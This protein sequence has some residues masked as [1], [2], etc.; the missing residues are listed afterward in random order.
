MSLEEQMGARIKNLREVNKLSLRKLGEVLGMDYSYLAKLEKGKNSPNLTTLRTITDYFGVTVSF[1]LGENE[2]KVVDL[3]TTT[4]EW[5]LVIKNAEQRGYSPA[6][7]IHI[8]EALE[9]I[10]SKKLDDQQDLVK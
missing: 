4:N 2:K 3:H 9:S 6:D 5:R 10:Q 1:I 8:F 7:V